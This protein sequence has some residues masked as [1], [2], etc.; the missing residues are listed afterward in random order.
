MIEDDERLAAMVSEY[1]GKSG[2]QVTVA[3]RA[4]RGLSLLARG[5]FH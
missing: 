3:P 4:E 5:G 2:L 1:L